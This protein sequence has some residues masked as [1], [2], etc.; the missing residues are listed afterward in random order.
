MQVLVVD[1]HP[2]V[3]TGLSTLLSAM[4][5]NVQVTSVGTWR[6]AAAH[7]GTP[8]HA[9]LLDLHLPD[10]DGL[11]ALG[12]ARETFP[13]VPIVVVS[14]DDDPALV[15]AAIEAGASGY[16]PKRN[17]DREIVTALRTVLDD[18][19]YLPPDVL[20]AAGHAAAAAAPGGTPPLTGRQLAVARL[21]IH[22]K[23]NKVISRELGIAEG[24][25]KSHLSIVFRVL[26]V[27]NRTEAVYALA[28]IG[29]HRPY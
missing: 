13:G 2:M 17:D 29:L 27:R 19:I 28:R 14:A 9:V 23:P 22:G 10:A 6:D 5:R 8:F 18:G 3:R 16:F 15:R 24:T 11:E 12:A 4:D 20:D 7:R 25:V 1:D 21:A 26:G